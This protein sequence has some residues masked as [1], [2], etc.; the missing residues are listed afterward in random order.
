MK[1]DKIIKKKVKRCEYYEKNVHKS[2]SV[3][4]NRNPK[5]KMTDSDYISTM[6]LQ[7]Q[8]KTNNNQ[9][10]L[11]VGTPSLKEGVKVKE[12]SIPQVNN[13]EGVSICLSAWNTQDYIEECLDSIANQ[14]WFKTHG[15]WEILL[16]IDACEKTLAKVKE[17][18]HK[19]K[20]LSVYMMDENVGTYVTCNTIMKLAKYEWLLRFDTDDVMY[21][22]MVETLMKK[23]EDADFVR[24]FMKNFGLKNTTGTSYGSALIKHSVFNK[25]NGYKD[26]RCD[27]DNDLNK[28]I[29]KVAKCKTINDILFNRR[30]HKNSLTV[31]EKTN[32]HSKVR[33]EHQTFV[34]TPSNYTTLEQC[35]L[36]KYV[37][38]T[39]RV[40]SNNAVNTEENEKH[41]FICDKKEGL[42]S[43]DGVSIII[44]AYKSEEFILETLN[45]IYN[46]T[47]TKYEIL[48]GVDGDINLL[49]FIQKNREKFNNVRL[50]YYPKNLGPYLIFNAMVLEAKYDKILR[51]DS[52]D[53]MPPTYIEDLVHE[54]G[55]YDA[56]KPYGVNFGL[57]TSEIK[58]RHGYFLI[59]KEKFIEIGGFQPWVCDADGE[60]YD[61]S[62]NILKWSFGTDIVFKRRIHGHNLINDKDKGLK[63]AIRTKYR[64]YRK[65]ISPQ[66]PIIDYRI[67]KIDSDIEKYCPIISFTTHGQRLSI[68]PKMLDS[69]LKQTY[70]PYKIIC[71]ITE[72]DFKKFPTQYKDKVE[73]V[74]LTKDLRPH[75]KY[76]WTMLKYRN[77]PIITIDDDC[78]YDKNLIK[79]LMSAYL[80][81][82]CKG[83]FSVRTHKKTFTNE[84]LNPYHAWKKGINHAEDNEKNLFATGVGGVLYSPNALN[85][86]EEWMS[87]IQKYITVDDMVLNYYETIQNIPIFHI[88]NNLEYNPIR[89]TQ[90][91]GLFNNENVTANDFA[92]NNLLKPIFKKL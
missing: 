31:D 48:I 88:D 15:N 1:T 66:N 61:R 89:E 83:V 74:I 19:Y 78:V 85:V 28:R 41:I 62:K 30:V 8:K 44:S 92:I 79:T 22:N 84:T 58:L 80:K 26:W 57:N 24:F 18:M 25:I 29:D 86:N 7:H 36:P 3:P 32:F 47:Y 49:Y 90:N 75:N 54:I 37:E 35:I 9:P 40:I 91:I 59:K 27:G 68:L 52:D 81:K 64:E 50:F 2:F 87:T 73:I 45:S 76:Y 6:Y 43:E 77:N 5:K 51:F 70:K 23:K 69:I 55:V 72:K 16:G 42:P 21:P 13:E 60:M 46:Q 14:T 53:I 63:S 67:I 20:N 4:Y 38:I 10:L 33:K 11:T 71:A 82:D 34:H 65:N 12:S 17:I 56:I 39:Y